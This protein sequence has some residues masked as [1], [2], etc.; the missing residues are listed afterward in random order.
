MQGKMRAFQ[1]VV[2][3][4]LQ[5]YMIQHTSRCPIG[6]SHISRLSPL[7]CPCACPSPSSL[8]TSSASRLASAAI[9]LRLRIA[10]GSTLRCPA[11][12]AAPPSVDPPRPVPRMPP[13]SGVRGVHTGGRVLPRLALLVVLVRP[14][15]F[16]PLCT[17]V[18]LIAASLGGVLRGS[19]T[20]ICVPGF[21][22]ADWPLTRLPPTCE[23]AATTKQQ[24]GPGSQVSFISHPPLPPKKTVLVVFCSI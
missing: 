8:S 15:R 6:M 5:K 22:D 24:G 3:A 10:A 1:N 17:K 14:P 23:T 7:S 16:R 2:S 12:A 19:T 11:S 20:R 18:R 21:A 13:A 9:T 4:Q